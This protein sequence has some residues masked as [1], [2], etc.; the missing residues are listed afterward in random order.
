MDNTTKL[1]PDTILKS[2]PEG[3]TDVSIPKK[4]R[5]VFLRADATKINKEDATNAVKK[6]CKELG[7]S[8]F[9]SQCDD[10]DLDF[11]LHDTT[12]NKAMVASARAALKPMKEFFT[13]YRNAYRYDD[14]TCEVVRKIM[15]LINNDD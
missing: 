5:I 4:T 10:V 6:L 1:N 2:L 15:R 13:K 7:L 8:I 3:F 11:R 9:G 12:Y 14:A